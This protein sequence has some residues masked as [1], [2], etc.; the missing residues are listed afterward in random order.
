MNRAATVIPKAMAMNGTANP[1]MCM[2]FL[3]TSRLRLPAV[4]IFSRDSSSDTV[5]LQVEFL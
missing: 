3:K 5:L 2:D 4:G 1:T